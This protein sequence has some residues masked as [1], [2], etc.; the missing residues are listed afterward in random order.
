MEPPRNM[1][2]RR[3][4]VVIVI[5]LLLAV[6]GGTYLASFPYGKPQSS[7]AGSVSTTSTTSPTPTISSSS[8][9]T[10]SSPVSTATSSSVASSAVTETAS[11]GNWTMY[12]K[13][14]SKSGYEPMANV[15]AV[16]ASWTSPVLDGQVY[17]EP[18]VLGQSVFVVTEN[19]SAYALNATTGSVLWRTHL[20]TPVPRSTLPCG[21]IDPLGITSTPVID[22][23]TKTLYLAAFLSPA[24]HV[25]FGLNLQSGAVVSQASADPPGADPSADQQRSALALANG[26]VYIAYGGLAGDCGPYH[27]WV[28]GVKAN[29]TSGLL[30]YEVPTGREGGIWAPSG[31]TVAP[32]GDLYVS[33]GNGNSTTTFDYSETVVRLS[34]T[35]KLLNY[36]GASNWLQ[37]N[38]GDV[39]IG[40]V[41]PTMMPNGEI[42]Q[43]GKEGVGYLLS[44]SDL[45]G[46]GGEAYSAQVCNGSWGGTARVGETLFVPCSNGL[47][48]VKVSQ[49]P[50]AFS[51]GWHA[52]NF[53]NDNPVGSPIVTGNVVWAVDPPTGRLMGFDLSTGD[54]RF[55]F[56]LQP[57][58]HFV[59]P[60]AGDGRLFVAAGDQ[61][62]SFVIS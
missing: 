58:D 23:A 42:F 26:V 15:T 54:Q 48:E 5:V 47:F 59:T 40:S 28:V 25:L 21:D 57:A 43:V 46:I 18:L 53:T 41:A 32:G 19:D 51:L 50:P 60:S 29:G 22:V 61:L 49:T 17:A 24:H 1:L 3:S 10:P 35:L 31:V 52:R 45:G 16:T 9:S 4:T 62:Y 20:G 27:G 14:N 38:S 7:T 34:P 8:L 39:D 36:W 12:H 37:L 56:S 30:T 2:T 55:S 33:V 11:G 6:A 44:S 13:D